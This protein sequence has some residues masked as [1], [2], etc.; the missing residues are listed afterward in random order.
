MGSEEDLDLLELIAIC[1]QPQPTLFP[2]RG[3]SG[4]KDGKFPIENKINP[5]LGKYVQILGKEFMTYWKEMRELKIEEESSMKS[6]K[7]FK[8]TDYQPETKS[9]SEQG[10]SSDT[11]SPPESGSSETRSPP[12]SESMSPPESDFTKSSAPMQPQ[13]PWSCVLRLAN[14]LSDLL[15]IEDGR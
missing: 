5:N 6:P 10:S 9:P 15:S 4:K 11:M 3:W 14:V 8:K 13:C 1:S 7:K 2:E 12:D